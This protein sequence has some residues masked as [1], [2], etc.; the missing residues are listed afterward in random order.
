MS[1]AGNKP[2]NRKRA[3]GFTLLETLVVVGIFALISALVVPNVASALNIMSLQQ[4]VRLM[5]ADLRVAHGTAM[6]TGE[7]VEVK[8]AGSS[9]YDF[10]GGSRMMPVGVTLSMS[11]T[12]SY[13]PDGT[14]T[15][16]QI[17]L[18]SHGR[19]Y[20]VIVDAATGGVTVSKQ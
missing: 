5:Q 9:R 10:I 13:Y 2:S 3:N 1:E 20:A 4:T 11:G 16:A 17:T 18:A 7:K 8:P 14:V 12:V 15:P 19:R 6:R